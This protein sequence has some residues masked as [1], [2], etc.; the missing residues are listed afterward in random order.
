MEF[1][2]LII[3][4]NTAVVSK[5]FKSSAHLRIEKQSVHTRLFSIYFFKYFN[6]SSKFSVQSK[7]ISMQTTVDTLWYTGIY[8]LQIVVNSRLYYKLLSSLTEL[9]K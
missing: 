9:K 1:K 5:I 3:R 7:I 6:Y 8:K 2:K 4:N